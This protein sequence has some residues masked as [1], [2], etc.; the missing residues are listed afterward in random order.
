MVLHRVVI[1]YYLEEGSDTT[2]ALIVAQI[3][4]Q[5]YEVWADVDG[6]YTADPIIFHASLIDNIDYDLIQEIASI[7]RKLCT[8]VNK[9]MIV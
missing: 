7:G 8:V 2:C 3:N 9:T 4:A 1:K 5:I 6:I